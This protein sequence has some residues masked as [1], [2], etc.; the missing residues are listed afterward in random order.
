MFVDLGCVSNLILRY[1][2]SVKLLVYI[3]RLQLYVVRERCN[4][5]M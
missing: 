4:H 1:I 2:L 3:L 5:N